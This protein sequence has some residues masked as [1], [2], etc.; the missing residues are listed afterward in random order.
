MAN[1][2]SSSVITKYVRFPWSGNSYLKPRPSLKSLNLMDI[3]LSLDVCLRVTV[4]SLQWFLMDASSP[5]T[6]VHVSSI[7]LRLVPDTSNQSCSPLLLRLNPSRLS[8]IT[9]LPLYERQYTGVSP[10]FRENFR[11]RLPSG[12]INSWPAA[13]K[14]GQTIDKNIKAIFFM[15]IL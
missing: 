15:F 11:Q 10:F 6:G 14:R 1:S 12:D 3:I 2:V 4:I 13:E 5:Q 7:S 9:G 8:A